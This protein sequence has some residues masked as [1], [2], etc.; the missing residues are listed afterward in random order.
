MLRDIHERYMHTGRHHILLLSREHYW[1][2]KGCYLACKMVSSCFTGKRRVVKP[3]A[4]LMADLTT[5]RPSIKQ[6][7]FTYT[8]VDYFGPI[9]VKFLRKTSRNQAITKRYGAIFICL[10]VRA[11][12]IELVSDLTT[13]AF[14]FQ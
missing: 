14:F 11:V 12:H 7:P 1:I 8:G 10:T 13:D 6:Q 3:V 5:E 9:Y 2:S 4:P